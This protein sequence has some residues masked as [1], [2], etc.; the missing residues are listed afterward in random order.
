M[1][2]HLRCL[3]VVAL[4]LAPGLAAAQD[5]PDAP[6]LPQSTITRTLDHYRV[7]LIR[8]G[9]V[10]TPRTGPSRSIEIRDGAIAID[11][12]TVSGRELRERIGD[13]ADL[14]LQLSYAAPDALRRAFAG[15]TAGT[16]T[17]PEAPSASPAAP[18]PAENEPAEAVPAPPAPPAAP[19]PPERPRHVQSGAKVRV[20][21]SVDVDENEIVRDAV[22]AVG[23]S[24]RV[25]GQVDDDVVAIGGSVRLGPKA[26]VNGS[27]TAVG[28]EIERAPG[29]VVHGEMTEVRVPMNPVALFAGMPVHWFGQEMFSSWFRFI[30][31]LL[32]I[33]LLMLVALIVVLAARTPVER[34]AYRAGADPWLSGMVGLLAQVLFIP[35]LVITIVVLAISIIGI[36]LLVL[37]PFA[38][39]ALLFGVVLGVTG[40]ARRIGTWAVGPDRGPLVATAVGV[41][42]I[43][44][45]ALLTRLT[46]L[47]PTH[48]AP[49]ALLLGVVAF[50]VEYAAWTVGLGALLL[51]RFGTRGPLTMVSDGYLPPIPP[52]PASGPA[53]VD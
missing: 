27:V 45:L 47:V 1:T 39:I 16:A 13:D 22:V 9:V 23:G 2:A 37:V 42:L 6:T 33:G 46:W 12:A 15:G 7:L 21:G 51:T 25:D 19:E 8:D 44:A 53:V 48:V 30:A 36:P 26:V 10:L 29:A 31:T 18:A 41:I 4:L 14:V 20:G 52:V 35:V 3:A 49:I 5:Q 43:T 11:G 40:V 32:R 34:I 50:F 24:V 17:P 28:G 38:L